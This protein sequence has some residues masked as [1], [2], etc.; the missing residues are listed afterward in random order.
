[1]IPRQLGVL[2]NID[3]AFNKDE[4]IDKGDISTLASI[5]KTNVQT[6]ST[7]DKKAI[8]NGLTFYKNTTKNKKF[9]KLKQSDQKTTMKLVH[10][11]GEGIE[12]GQATTVVDSTVEECAGYQ[13]NLGNRYKRRHSDVH[14]TITKI[15]DHSFY[16]ST[17]RNLH[18]P[19]IAPRETR[20]KVVWAKDEKGTV[21]IDVSDSL[22]LVKTHR[23]KDGHV[24]MS[25]HVVW[26]FERLN[27]MGKTP[28]TKVTLTGKINLG[29]AIHSSIMNRLANR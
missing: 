29:G 20:T 1:L 17:S 16:Y 6:Y 21:V 3:E 2:S 24:L 9:T 8:T 25:I 15:N 10:F 27:P 11:H 22:E 28:Q 14:S 12:T 19:G 23:L 7:E 26:V 4:E 5:M 13:Y 18:V